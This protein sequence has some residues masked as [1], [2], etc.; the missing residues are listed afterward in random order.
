MTSLYLLLQD[1]AVPADPSQLPMS[2]IP[3]MFEYSVLGTILLAVI[4]IGGRLVWIVA[5]RLVKA[6]TTSLERQ[7]SAAETTAK[8]V[9]KIADAADNIADEVDGTWKA[10]ERLEQG[11]ARQCRAVRH[12]VAAMQRVV[13]QEHRDA[14][15]LLAQAYDELTD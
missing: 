9:E 1:P 6:V 3:K 13:P 7:A 15:G 11:H 5:D 8:A 14:H 10:V 4:V 2:D 12:A